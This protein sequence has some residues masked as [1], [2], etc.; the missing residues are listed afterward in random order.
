MDV[1]KE[2]DPG[3]AG[4]IVRG[5]PV[6]LRWFMNVLPLRLS[7]SCFSILAA[8]LALLGNACAAGDEDKA[9]AE[10]HEKFV[11]IVQDCVRSHVAARG[12]NP[13]QYI[14]PCRAAIMDKA[15]ECVAK[16]MQLQRAEDIVASAAPEQ[17][18]A[19]PSGPGRVVIVISGVE[20][21][22]DLQDYATKI[23][24]LGY[25]TALID[26]RT[27][28]SIDGKGG[29]RLAQIVAKAQSSTNAS[30]GKIAVIGFGIGG[31]GA[32]AHAEALADKVAGVITYYPTT[33]FIAKVSDMKSFVGR[34][35][36]PLLAFAAA[37]DSAN[38]CCVLATI[39]DMDA[40]AKAQGKT[41][42]L[43][44]YPNADH[45]F[46]A[47]PNYRVDDAADAWQRT[48]DALHQYL[49]APPAH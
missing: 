6:I 39:Q 20:G 27:I 32:L 40:Q 15:R 49:D 10:C 31:G 1:L 22:V 23:S 38:N 46:A 17:D 41:M 30:P 25:Y 24:Q 35:R 48:T 44:V 4:Q 21:P 7:S 29:E 8:T 28:L 11:P 14:E 13:K 12:G 45:N 47:G 19:A 9:R 26:G 3:G 42:Q 34:F 37:N 43:V 33:S 5:V 16:L 36:V 18:I 2:H